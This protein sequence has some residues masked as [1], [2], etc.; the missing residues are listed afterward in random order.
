MTFNSTSTAP[1]PLVMPQT[2]SPPASTPYSNGL[3][4]TPLHFIPPKPKLSFST[5]PYFPQP[6]L[7]HPP[8]ILLNMTTLPYSKH[9]RNLGLHIDSAISLDTHITNMHK[10]IHYHLHCFRLIRRSIPFPIAVTIASSYILT[11]FDY[12]NNLLFNLSAYKRIKLQRLQN[13]VV[14]CVH[15]LPR[16]SSD[17]ITPILKQLH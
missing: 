4:P 12:C 16:H 6:S 8:P 13:A 7:N 11:L 14:R 2:D 1:T 5:Y 17:S 15:L 10:S 9:V 3:L